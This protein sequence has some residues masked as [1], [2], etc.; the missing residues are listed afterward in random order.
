MTSALRLASSLPRPSGVS[1][2]HS[3]R[4]VAK[5]D[6]LTTKMAKN[7]P[8]TRRGGSSARS[9]RRRQQGFCGQTGVRG[10]LFR[11]LVAFFGHFTHGV[12]ASPGS[13]APASR[14]TH[15]QESISSASACRLVL[16]SPTS[17]R[18][19]VPC[20]RTVPCVRGSARGGP[21]RRL[22]PPP[23]G[24]GPGSSSPPV[25]GPG[26]SSARRRREG[27]APHGRARALLSPGRALRNGGRA[28]PGKAPGARGGG[29]GLRCASR[30]RAAPLLR[31]LLPNSAGRVQL[32]FADG[33]WR[34]DQLTN[35]PGRFK[36][37]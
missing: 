35:Q 4:K 28:R 2:A 29:G 26:R 14:F 3:H 30:G 34:T 8:S 27:A 20:V 36:K 5:K 12:G 1:C 33:R 13:A 10:H 24:G 19:P 9:R 31:R 21:G 18:C 15:G 7:P 17:A 22:A 6:D 23:P 32:G 25:P 16:A 11:R 37:T